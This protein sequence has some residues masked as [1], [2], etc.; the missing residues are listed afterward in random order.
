MPLLIQTGFLT[1]KD[2]D[3]RRST[4]TLGYPNWEVRQAFSTMVLDTRLKLP[5]SESPQIA[6]MDIRD[7]FEVKKIDDVILHLNR[8]IA[9]IPGNLHT[10]KES[11]YHSLIQM[12]FQTSGLT[13]RSEEWVAGGRIDTVIE[14][15]DCFYIIEF[16]FDGTAQMAI[17]QIKHRKYSEKFQANGK[18]IYGLG[19]A[20]DCQSK[21]I[22]E[23]K[24]GCLS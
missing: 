22:S 16:K 2:Y 13:V 5:Y 21:S 8:L 3:E 23:W 18:S 7:A 15:P 11:Y 10:P 17:D 1:I 24:L 14:E 20:V 19:I 9:A 12:I 4:Y 6:A